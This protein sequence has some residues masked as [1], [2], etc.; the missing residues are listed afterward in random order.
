[1]C[2]IKSN[3]YKINAVFIVTKDNFLVLLNV[4][5]HCFAHHFCFMFMT[6]ESLDM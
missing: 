2:T 3:Y 5:L 4:Y 1:M 6:H